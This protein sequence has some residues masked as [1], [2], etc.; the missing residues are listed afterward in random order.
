MEHIEFIFIFNINC[1]TILNGILST[2]GHKSDVHLSPSPAANYYRQTHNH[3]LLL[4]VWRKNEKNNRIL[5]S[6]YFK[7]T[8]KNCMLSL[9]FLFSAFISI[10]IDALDH[11]L[12][13]PT[14][15]SAHI[16]LSIPFYK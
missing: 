16:Y 10:S 8:N 4:F 6:G 9:N 2:C 5:S 15:S 11:C 14:A 1:N 13:E 7:K 12:M 3:T